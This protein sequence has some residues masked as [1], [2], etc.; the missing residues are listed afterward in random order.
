MV[1]KSLNYLR[2]VRTEMGKVSWPTRE[3]LIEST[4]ITLLLA[5]LMSAFIFFADQII[6]R[7]INIIL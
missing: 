3:Q 7:I 1:K 6:S 2:N 5:L 4:G